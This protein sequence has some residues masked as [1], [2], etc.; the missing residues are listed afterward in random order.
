MTNASAPAA[1]AMADQ[2]TNDAGGKARGYEK[3]V[4]AEELASVTMFDYSRAAE[5]FPTRSRKPRRQ[6]HSYRRFARAAE[7]IRY[8]IEELP[9]DLLLGACLQV[10]EERFGSAGIRKLYDSERYPLKRTAALRQ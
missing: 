3:A 6:A 1:A 5:L 7:A 8:A 2:T 10:E 9:R 4:S